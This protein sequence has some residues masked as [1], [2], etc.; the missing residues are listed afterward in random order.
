MDAFI[1]AKLLDQI[2]LVLGFVSGGLLIPEVINLLP[3][4]KIQNSIEGWLA[5][6]ENWA[7]RFPRRFYPPSW[8]MKY[9]EDEREGRES[10]TAIRTLIFSIVWMTIL[11]RGILLSSTFLILLGLGIP[12]L[13]TLG[14][15]VVHLTLWRWIKPVA[16][17]IIF[18]SFFL[19]LI[20][21]TPLLSLV[22]VVLLFLRPIV[23]WVHRF[24]SVR[25]ILRTSL[26]ALAIIFFILS[27]ILQFVA[28]FL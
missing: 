24:F 2:G 21:V 17:V 3:L 13:I 10:I 12:F 11:A 19:I 6:F 4:T 18:I 26:I 1:T 8:K 14:N 16:L 22:R 25:Q 27:N 28:T 5:A 23:S 20:F 7:K 9:T 15:M